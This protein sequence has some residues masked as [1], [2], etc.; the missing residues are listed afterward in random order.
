MSLLQK[1]TYFRTTECEA[2]NKTE[3]QQFS[4]TSWKSTPSGN[5]PEFTSHAQPQQTWNN[6]HYWS[7]SCMENGNSPGSVWAVLS[8]LLRCHRKV[9]AAAQG[10]EARGRPE[11]P[12]LKSAHQSGSAVSYFFKVTVC[13]AVLWTVWVL[14]FA[15]VFFLSSLV[16]TLF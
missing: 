10:L 3:K 4:Y 12:A 6:C 9:W 14:C 15:T 16:L 13:P 11:G 8:G 7:A 1:H 2:G 5:L